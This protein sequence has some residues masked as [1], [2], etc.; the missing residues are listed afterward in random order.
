[1]WRVVG[2]GCW[3]GGLLRVGHGALNGNA[4]WGTQLEL[5]DKAAKKVYMPN[6][7]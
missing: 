6:L 7:P 2:W 1:M 5:L 4:D 3:G